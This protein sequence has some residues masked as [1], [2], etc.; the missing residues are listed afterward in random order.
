M[1]KVETLTH[2]TLLRAMGQSSA[3]K[4]RGAQDPDGQPVEIV[5][6]RR[7]AGHSS[8]HN[9]LQKIIISSA[10]KDRNQLLKFT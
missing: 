2:L 3:R 5:S 8:F 9:S 1:L 4:G 6:A 10:F 7:I